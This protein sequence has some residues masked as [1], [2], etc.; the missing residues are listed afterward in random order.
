MNR[1]LFRPTPKLPVQAMQT[2]HILAPTSTHFRRATCEEI[3]CLP[4][5]HGW[6]L[7]LEGLDEGDIW[8]ARNAGRRYHQQTNEDGA[9]FLYFEA[10]QPCFRAATHTKRVDRPE[11]FIVR[12]G[13]WRGSDGEEPIR[14]SGADAWA[15]HLGTSLDRI[16]SRL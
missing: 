10:G 5:H 9:H 2:H 12:N 6:V 11:L 14:F 8:Q 16:A 7:P 1:P 13:D 3:G 4:F 15:D